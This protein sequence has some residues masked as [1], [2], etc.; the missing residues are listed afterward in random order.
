[1]DLVLGR[2]IEVAK[3]PIQRNLSF[4]DVGS[5]KLAPSMCDPCRLKR[6][7]KHGWNKD[8]APFRG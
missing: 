1:M 4:F 6:T 7:L 2:K 8:H 3:P 5:P